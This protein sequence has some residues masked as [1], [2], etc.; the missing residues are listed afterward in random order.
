MIKVS[1][2]G[3]SAY[4][5]CELID[6]L[7]RHPEV[8]IVH[9]G[10]RREGRPEI[11][12]I[13]PSLRGRCDMRL[14]GPGPDDAPEKPDVAF[15][16]LPHGISQQYVPEYLKAGV[17]CIDFSSDYRF[18]DIGVYREHYGEHGDP[19]NVAR[20]VY[21]IPE[22]FRN[23]IKGAD[24]VA[25]PGCY[26]TSVLLG[27]APLLGTGTIGAGNIVVDAKSGVS[28]RGNKPSPGSLY[29]ECNENITAY[30][31]GAHRHAPEM[32]Q[33][34]RMLGGEGAGVLF[35][36]HLVPM[37]RGILSTI[38][39]GLT[40]DADPAG[41]Q[42]T[43][44]DYYA[45]EPFIRVLPAGRQPATKNVMRTNYCDIA[46][47]PVGGGRAVITSAIDNLG[48]G[49]ASQAVQNMNAMLG[50]DEAL[51]LR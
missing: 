24:L 46:V 38:Y 11:S 48:R 15:F 22:L 5:G 50:L 47:E 40:E 51:G 42:S 36:P 43:M 37:D 45:G 28:G 32:E 17:R 8:E 21:G 25:N 41:I 4:T 12:G 16:T 39:V 44:A 29:C 19:Q 10:G 27:L 49:A 7:L 9:L 33:G 1:I 23:R 30:S 6:I 35:V 14:G 3:A 13:F 18:A 34:I 2:V 26:P 31:I 20:A